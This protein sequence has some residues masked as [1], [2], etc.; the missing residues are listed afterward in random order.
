MHSMKGGCHACI[1]LS[2]PGSS[3][4]CFV[5]T[6]LQVLCSDC[7]YI[8]HCVFL[9]LWVPYEVDRHEQGLL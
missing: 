2:L 6:L 5:L 4:R 3:G 1:P 7:P 8:Q 9:K